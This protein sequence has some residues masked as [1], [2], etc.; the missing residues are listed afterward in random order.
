MISLCLCFGILTLFVIWLAFHMDGRITAEECERENLQSRTECSLAHKTSELSKLQGAADQHRLQ[1]ESHESR[2]TNHDRAAAG[3]WLTAKKEL[4]RIRDM[5]TGHLRN[6]VDKGYANGDT[7]VKMQAEIARREVDARWRT[8]D[9]ETPAKASTDFRTK[10]ALAARLSQLR[11]YSTALQADKYT[12]KDERQGLGRAVASATA[13]LENV[14]RGGPV[15]IGM[16]L[17]EWVA[18]EPNPK[19]AAVMREKMEALGVKPLQN[20]LAEDVRN[21]AAKIVSG[22]MPA[23]YRKQVSERLNGLAMEAHKVGLLVSPLRR[24]ADHLQRRQGTKAA[25]A[26]ALRTWA[27]S[28]NRKAVAS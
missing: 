20:A 4:L 6:A 19:S 12:S 15:L 27:D 24:V 8:T 5:S 1:L 23:E 11:N 25:A 26:E 21:I 7:L 14:L 22:P 13:E 18:K 9:A 2:L 28:I 10:L 3:F 16:D 17:C